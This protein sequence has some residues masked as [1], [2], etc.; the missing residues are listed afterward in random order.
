[1]N[2]EPFDTNVIVRRLQ[3][4]AQGLHLVGSAADYAAVKELRSFRTPSA[5]VVFADEENTGT[6]PTTFC[7]V[8]VQTKVQFGVVLALRNY[9]EQLGGQMGEEAR[10]L[11][12]QVRQV[13]CP[14][15]K[16]GAKDC[17]DGPV[18][19]EAGVFP[20]LVYHKYLL[21]RVGGA[22]N[23]VR[24]DANASGPLFFHG[25]GA[26]DL[27][28]AGAVLADLLAVARDE[29]PNNTGFVGKE[30]PKASIVPPEEWRSC[31]YVRVMVQD[32]PGV[33]RDLSG[34]MAAEGISMAQVIQKSDEGN[35]VPLVFMT[36]ETTAR[37]M[38]DALQ[39]TMDA[40]LLKEPAVYFRVL[41]GE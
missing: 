9:Q 8:Q 36:H 31:Y 10:K 32:T 40:G 33:L 28:T 11:I 22:Y 12:G 14:E 16:A 34:C 13:P 21:A 27:P 1:M 15:E 29:R 30:L 26:G 17:G 39:R 37:A 20:A 38:S 35:G 24:V 4:Q 5:Y 2:F 25:R 23:A 6:L 3:A 41:G 18:R 19:L 7:T